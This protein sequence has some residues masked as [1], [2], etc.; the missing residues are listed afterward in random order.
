MMNILGWFPIL[1]KDSSCDTQL[2]TTHCRILWHTFFLWFSLWK[3]WSFL[4]FLVFIFLLLLVLKNAPLDVINFAWQ[5]KAVLCEPV[6]SIGLQLINSCN[7]L[8]LKLIIEELRLFLKGRPWLDI[9]AL[10]TT[11]IIVVKSKFLL[12]LKI[13]I[14]LWEWTLCAEQVLRRI[15]GLFTKKTFL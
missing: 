8:I 12:F 2:L 5:F 3:A 15:W 6:I 11:N 4:A 7:I 14:W 9:L 13:L 10:T 1:A